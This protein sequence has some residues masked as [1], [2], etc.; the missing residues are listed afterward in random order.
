M[1]RTGKPL[2][3]RV[4]AAMRRHPGGTAMHDEQRHERR[5]DGGVERLRSPER[6]ARL[7]VE[8]VVARVLDGA[9]AASAL[10]VGTGTGV[11]AQALVVRGL[12]VTGVDVN[13]ELLAAARDLVPE[14]AFREGI[15]ESLPFP[16]RSFD[17]VFLGVVLHE[18][19]DAVAA[20]REAGRVARRR[21]AVLEWPY[22]ED[23]ERPPL[24]HRLSAERVRSLAAAAGLGGVE[25]V[26]LDRVDLYLMTP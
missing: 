21:V 19:D 9:E 10:D 18:T 2:A 6:L 8:R 12:A 13:P 5:Y 17:L 14:A 25:I 11:F 16:D 7:G 20:L 4:P 24:A 1:G 26:P 15:A 3:L 23:G 22:R